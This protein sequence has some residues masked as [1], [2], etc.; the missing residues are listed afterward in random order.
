MS[1]EERADED[2]ANVEPE[3]ANQ[4]N[5]TAKASRDRPAAGGPVRFS[6]DG[7]R[8]SS[9][10][11]LQRRVALYERTLGIAVLPVLLRRLAIA[12]VRTISSDPDH[13][14]D[15][16][17]STH[18]PDPRV[19]VDAGPYETGRFRMFIDPSS[20][21]HG[22]RQMA[23]GTY[24]ETFVDALR[25]H[26]ALQGAVVWD[27]GAHI[28]YESLLFAELVGPAGRVVAF[29]PNPANFREWQRN[30]EGNSKLAARMSLRAT[31]LCDKSG[32]AAFRFSEDVLG[33]GSSGSH[34]ADAV[35]PEDE[36]SYAAFGLVNVACARADDLVEAGEIAPPA[37]IKIDVEGA[38]ADVVRGATR[39]LHRYKPIL[40]VEVHHVRAMHDL[41]VLLQE[42]G[43]VSSV[44]EASEETASR[45]FLKA[46]PVNPEPPRAS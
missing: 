40:L 13:A 27:V 7:Q 8:S 11:G 36:V 18:R 28:G 24:D 45:C 4:P 17:S 6:T 2:P 21:G 35:P 19:W 26:S 12:L 42:A 38:E 20:V 33:G 34:L 31:A 3:I 1:V 37:I 29:E 10:L 16:A 46:V 22:A 41:E 25:P 39:T 9:P 5:S 43:Y 14:P 15:V 23:L 32:T 30:V 44:L